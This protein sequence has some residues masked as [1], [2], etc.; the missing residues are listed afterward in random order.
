MITQKTPCFIEQN[1]ITSKYSDG[2]YSLL[3][4]PSKK[5]N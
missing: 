2:W 3:K 1:C 4:K 5:L